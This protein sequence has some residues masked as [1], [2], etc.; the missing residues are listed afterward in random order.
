MNI[1]TSAPPDLKYSLGK[2]TK[3][4]LKS[5]PSAVSEEALCGPR[6]TQFPALSLKSYLGQALGKICSPFKEEAHQSELWGHLSGP[7]ASPT[8][9]LQLHLCRVRAW[10]GKLNMQ[11]FQGQTSPGSVCRCIFKSLPIYLIFPLCAGLAFI[12]FTTCSSHSYYKCV[13]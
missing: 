2:G 1:P 8:P 12:S 11:K 4:A 3:P 10:K 9:Q 7:S 13:A 5:W 6:T